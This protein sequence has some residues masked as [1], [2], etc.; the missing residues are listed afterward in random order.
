VAVT[1]SANIYGPG[2]LNLSR[3]VPSAIVSVLNGEPPIIRSDGTPVREFV[4][5]GD[6]VKGYLDLAENIPRVQ[7]EAFNLGTDERIRILDLVNMIIRLMGKDGVLAPNI[8]LKA[9]IEREIDEQY[10]SSEKIKNRIGWQAEITLEEGLQKTIKWY[11]SHL[12]EI[13]R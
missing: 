6:V 10:L 7:G 1:R 11:S 4:F 2:D 13:S 9:K 12:H 5:V 3:I 8:L